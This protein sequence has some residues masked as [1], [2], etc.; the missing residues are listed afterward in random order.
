MDPEAAA[1]VAASGYHESACKTIKAST[2]EDAS[3][4]AARDGPMLG[5]TLYR[6]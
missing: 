6:P 2:L 4:D 5:F 3:G 1:G